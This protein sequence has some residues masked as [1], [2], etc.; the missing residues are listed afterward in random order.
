MTASLTEFEN[1]DRLIFSKSDRKQLVE[2]LREW[3]DCVEGQE[4]LPIH[5]ICLAAYH[6]G[7][8]TVT[9]DWFRGPG[10]SNLYR[11]HLLIRLG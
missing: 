4:D 10:M 9:T 5:G 3:A 11:R 8:R 2:L 1:L 6:T 7:T